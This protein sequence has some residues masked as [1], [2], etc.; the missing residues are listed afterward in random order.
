MDRRSI[1]PIKRFVASIWEKTVESDLA[2]KIVSSEG[3]VVDRPLAVGKDVD[4]STIAALT[5]SFQAFSTSA[6]VA[7][8][9]N[10]I[11]FTRQWESL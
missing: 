1:E 6:P 10:R 8:N 3:G 7:Q 2:G 11:L 4:L 9:R 5:E